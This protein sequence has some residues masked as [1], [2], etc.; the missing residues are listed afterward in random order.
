[1]FYQNTNGTANSGL[2]GG[3]CYV[4]CS[5]AVLKNCIFWENRALNTNLTGGANV[6]GYGG[7]AIY[8]SPAQVQNCLFYRNDSKAN[9]GGLG[10]STMGTKSAFVDNCTFVGNTASNLGGGIYMS[11]FVNVVARNSIIWSNTAPTHADASLATANLTNCCIKDTNGVINWNTSGNITGNP[12]FMNAS[13]D[14][15]RLQNNSPCVNAGINQNWMT[16]AV[17]L[18][19]KS[20]ICYGTVDMGAYECIHGGAIC[21]FK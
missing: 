1:M 9:G 20:R 18:D 7:V 2:G 17:D 11:N 6:Q 8:S 13:A 3:L 15:Y 21:V 5:L 4:N 10:F 12:S 16:N 19:G 14:N